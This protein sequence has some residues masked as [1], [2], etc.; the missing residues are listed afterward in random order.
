MLSHTRS[1][2]TFVAFT[3]LLCFLSTSSCFA[4]GAKASAK[5]GNSDVDKAATLE[6]PK[7][8]S[9]AE[10]EKQKAELEK[11]KVE[12]AK[13]QSYRDYYKAIHVQLK[14][15]DALNARMKN[16]SGL[17]KE[18]SRVRLLRVNK[19]LS[20]QVTAWLNKV[21]K[22]QRAQFRVELDGDELVSF[23][24]RV[25]GQ[26]LKE[27]NRLIFEEVRQ[28]KDGLDPAKQAVADATVQQL[29]VD[30]DNNQ[31]HYLQALNLTEQFTIDV[32]DQRE[33]FKRD[34]NEQA[35]TLSAGLSLSLD[36]SQ[37]LGMSLAV[38]AD[39]KDI[40]R[41]RAIIDNR[42]TMFSKQL[43]AII[44]LL[45][46][47]GIDTSYYDQQIILATGQVSS[48]ILDAKVAV[49]IVDRMLDS[50][51]QSLASNAPVVFFKC[52][53][54]LVI[55]FVA[56]KLSRLV[57]KLMTKAMNSSRVPLSSLLQ[58]MIISSAANLIV[59]MGLLIALSQVGVSLGP[60]LAGLGVA[61]FIIGFALQDSMSNFA[62]GILILLYRPFDKGDVIEAGGVLGVVKKMSLVN[63]TIHSLD[64]QT[65]IIPNNTI[66]QGTIKN[67]T[68]QRIRRVDMVF[69]ISYSDD[70]AKTE[71]ILN[72][73]LEA[74]ERVLSEPEA[75]VRV[76]ELGDSSVNF[77]VRPWV[78]TED[79]WEVHWAV[80]RAV[81]MR[82]DEQGITIPFPQ[83]DVHHHGVNALPVAAKPPVN[84]G[85]ES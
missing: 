44:N 3:F 57:R 26:A 65:F 40:G 9:D 21:P 8:L 13:Q 78:K 45:N 56:Y 61:G 30:L 47:M 10:L 67:L 52:L 36:K 19:N 37:A 62:S 59:F 43:T 53:I 76:H 66:W 46:E 49:G 58:R 39:D 1:R 75:F 84:T 42:I 11:Q 74:D 54:V 80:T 85:P 27:R 24:A 68:E 5:G 12:E 4:E 6:Q 69:G 7:E 25:L 28:H 77:V 60:V 64:N 82:F 71:K 23:S 81:K 50:A 14:K 33:G 35:E 51:W 22:E 31:Q 63:T 18:L 38:V 70:I 32:D 79:Y 48:D 29:W 83:M 34:L 17:A 72:E 20:T 16:E 55:I 15:I 73:I 2:G 41:D